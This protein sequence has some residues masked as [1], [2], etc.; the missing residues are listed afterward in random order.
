MSRRILY[1]V[2]A[3][4][5]PVLGDAAAGRAEA[6]VLTFDETL[7][8]YIPSY[9]SSGFVLTATDGFNV[10]NSDDS[11]AFAGSQALAPILGSEVLLRR[12]DGDP[13]SLLSIDLARN[14][15]YDPGPTVTFTGALSGGG[16]V[17]RTFTVNNPL[18]I[19][20]NF[21][22]INM[23]Q[24]FD[25]GGDFTNLVSVRWTQGASVSAGLHQFDDIRLGPAGVTAIPEASTLVMSG[26]VAS[27]ALLGYVRQRRRTVDVTSR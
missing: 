27:L 11:F 12:A 10:N 7:P 24:P 5:V 14:W 1:A 17:S 15:A 26:C 21:N 20:Q 8:P 2:L 6:Q 18:P 16:T 19:D 9:Q 23:F 22:L 3:L 13:F 4:T 25:F